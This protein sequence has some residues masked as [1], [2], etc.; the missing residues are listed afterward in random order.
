[1]GKV[2]NN[3]ITQGFS[4]KYSEDLTF[5]QIGGKTFFARRGVSSGPPSPRQ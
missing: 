2:K 3:L 1:M 5:R 4:G